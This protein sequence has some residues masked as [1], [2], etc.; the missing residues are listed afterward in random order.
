MNPTDLVEHFFRH[1]YGRL[2]SLLVCRVGVQRIAD[3]EDA[4]QGA[5]QT[6]LQRWPQSGVPDNPSAWLYQV[7]R[8]RLLDGLRTQ[9][10]RGRLLAADPSAVT[11]L[12]LDETLPVGLEPFGDELLRM[13]FV[14]AAPDISPGSQLVL[15]LKTLCGF[16]VREIAARL[17]L[18]E[19]NV[20]KR[21]QRARQQLQEF[22]PDLE[23]GNPADQANRLP[24]VRHMLY[25]LF[26]EGHLSVRPGR[27]IRRDLCDEALRLGELL[28]NHPVDRS[29]QTAALLA[30]FHLTA[31]RLGA[32]ED[33]QGGV[34][35]LEEQNRK[36]WDQQHIKKGLQWLLRSTTGETFSRYHAEAS[37]AAE[38]AMAPSFALTRWDRIAETYAQLE[39]LAPSPLHTLNRALATAEWKGPAAG[40]E[41]LHDLEAPS[42]LLDSHLWAAVHADLHRRCGH[43]KEA[44]RFTTLALDTAPN[45]AIRHQLQR[46]LSADPPS[47]RERS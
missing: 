9:S 45:D 8:N 25:L 22:P 17:F 43:L 37:I 46:R 26:T 23:G 2:V 14:C 41:V 12:P 20:H 19:A 38:H 3:I 5:L 16:Q 7:T 36:T 13:L 10:N 28:A 27:A 47:N 31:A 44:R 1:E 15:A 42:W 40:L 18:N 34:L 39:A 4:V 11:P 33:D 35:L 32:R 6:A 21:L 24:A 29:P 30:L